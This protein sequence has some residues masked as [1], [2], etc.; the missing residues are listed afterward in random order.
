MG[1][2]KSGGK[3]M[4]HGVSEKKYLCHSS[5]LFFEL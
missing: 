4:K 3:D 1:N 5:L 2:L